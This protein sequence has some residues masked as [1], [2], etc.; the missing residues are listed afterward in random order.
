MGD[1]FAYSNPVYDGYFAD[2]AVRC[3]DGI[4]WAYG[5][6]NGPQSDGREFP[7]LRSE[8]LA[9]WTYVGGALVKPDAASMNSGRAAFTAY[10]AP[11]VVEC[12]GNFYLY[13]SAATAEGDTT[14]RLRVA[15]AD[16]PAGPFSDAGRVAMP[17]ALAEAFCIDAHPFFDPG[18]GR[19]YLFFATD[20][21]DGRVGTGTAAFVL[22]KDMCSAAGEA[23]TVLRPWADWM[24]YQRDRRL[25]GR[26]W[27]AWHTLEGPWVWPH[28]GKYYCFYSGGNWQTAQYGVGCGVAEHPLGPWRDEWNGPGPSVL[29]GVAGKI[30]GPGHASIAAGPEGREFIVYHAWDLAGRT[31]RMCIDP[32]VWTQ[33]G[34]KCA[35]A[36]VGEVCS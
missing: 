17:A 14:H 24:I 36:T 29:S 18:E 6:G 31:R 12:N 16:H 30:L 8:D 20:F 10:W 26:T 32:L 1:K 7:I 5:T 34:P 15:V 9:H 4:Y 22:G 19:W 33:G 35:G 21:F 23:R 27:A 28:E 13:Y 2:P 25:Y 3:F 11:E